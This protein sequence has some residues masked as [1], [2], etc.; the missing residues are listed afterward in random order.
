MS[1]SLE[2]GMNLGVRG[3]VGEQQSLLCPLHGTEHGRG[4]VSRPNHLPATNG[5]VYLCTFYPPL[6]SG[7]EGPGLYPEEPSKGF[8]CSASL[9]PPKQGDY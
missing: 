4:G 1:S 3:T 5:P 8:T 9:S 6:H 2:H 7:P